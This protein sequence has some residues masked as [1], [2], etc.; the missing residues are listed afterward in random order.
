MITEAYGFRVVG[1]RAGR[2]R[3]VDWRLAFTAYCAC[4]ERA[5]LEREAYLSHFSYGRDFHEYLEREGSEKGY[6][7]PCGADWLFWDIDRADDLDAALSD[8]RRLAAGI[9]DRYR[10]L[11][12]DDLLIFLSGGKGF[13]V[14][15]TTLLWGPTPS[16]RFNETA[17]RFALA[18]A[19]RAGIVVDPL[20]YSKTRLFRAPNSRHQKTGLYK[21][22]LAFDE[23]MNMKTEAIAELARQPMPFAVP[24][25][26]APS[27]TA[28]A[29]WLDAAGT[30]D[31]RVVK[32]R[33]TD[34]TGRQPTFADSSPKLN[35]LTL[36]FIRDG[37]PD[38]ERAVRL[39]QAAA[40][41]AEFHCPAGL[42]HALLTDAALDSGLTP[43]E[44]RRQIECGLRHAS[45]QREGGAA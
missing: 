30:V 32:R 14:G 18:H 3:S 4:D 23:L 26:A 7:G 8:A 43:C 17:K 15:L 40:N 34:R 27:P 10:E 36:A 31:R 13:H 44:T 35:A 9:L 22:R 38:G 6:S 37:A 2:R 12:D 28:V 24:T 39:F 5:Q 42:A 21:R 19:E 41:L 45:Q 1:H 25:T 29:D 20:I 33:A 11:G 16:T